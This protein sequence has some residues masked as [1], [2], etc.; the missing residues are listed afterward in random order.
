MRTQRTFTVPGAI[1]GA[2]ALALTVLLPL[3]AGAAEP[4]TVEITVTDRGY[5]PARIELAAGETVRL[6]FHQRAKSSCAHSVK[7]PELGIE[8][9]DLPAGET[10]V[11]EITP[12]EAGEFTFACGMDMLEGAVIVKR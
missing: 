7:S 8:T 11:I 1:L 12:D 9:T 5:E 6:A 10:T 3:A 4:R 2:C